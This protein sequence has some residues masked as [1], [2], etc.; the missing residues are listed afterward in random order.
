LGYAGNYGAYIQMTDNVISTGGS[1]PC[2]A[3]FFGVSRTSTYANSGTA[4]AMNSVIGS[5]GDSG[6]YTGNGLNIAAAA[7]Q[8]DVSSTP[9]MNMTGTFAVVNT[10][11]RTGI[12]AAPVVIE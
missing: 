9:A 11:Y 12:T 3:M 4:S 6:K 10:G 5:C 8:L 2:A 1:Q 7:S